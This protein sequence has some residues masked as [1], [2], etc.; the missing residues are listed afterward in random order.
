MKIKLDKGILELT[1]N[2]KALKIRAFANKE[3]CAYLDKNGVKLLL[4]YVQN[5]YDKI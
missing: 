2:K 3:G 5:V 1:Q 4:D